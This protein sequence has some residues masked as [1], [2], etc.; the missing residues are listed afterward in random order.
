M[1]IRPLTLSV[2]DQTRI[3]SK[4]FIEL[5]LTESGA[6]RLE[7]TA[8]TPKDQLGILQTDDNVITS[9]ML[10][11]WQHLAVTFDGAGE[12]AIYLNGTVL[13]ATVVAP[14]G[15]GIRRN[16]VRALEIGEF[17]GFSAIIDE[18]RLWNIART[19]DEIALTSKHTLYGN[20]S[21]LLGYWKLD[22]GQGNDAISTVET[23]P[24]ASLDAPR[25]RNGWEGDVYVG[26][27]E[28]TYSRDFHEGLTF[29]VLPNPVSLGA[30]SVNVQ[31][32]AQTSGDATLTLV[33]YLGRTIL[34]QSF[35][36]Q[37]GVTRSIAV[38]LSGLSSGVYI[39][40]LSTEGKT[41]SRVLVVGE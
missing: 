20:E 2:Q 35:V 11:E 24:D 18:I 15:T 33:D 36:Q 31:F 29:K 19:A 23:A 22:D 4:R 17:V 21:G 13:P 26:V 8:D 25:W 39:C 5:F 7:V 9:S 14:F 34:S 30:S 37:A 16:R 28:D 10:D 27:A 40:Q 12:A 41:L 6:L 32:R 38:P 1:F 3:F